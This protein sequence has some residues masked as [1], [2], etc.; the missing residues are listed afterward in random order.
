MK[1]QYINLNLVHSSLPFILCLSISYPCTS[2]T[3]GM[4]ALEG[5]LHGWSVDPQ[6]FKDPL[7]ERGHLRR[8]EALLSLLSARPLYLRLPVSDSGRA[9]IWWWRG[10]GLL[11]A[12]HQV[13]AWGQQQ[14][15]R[16][17][18]PHKRC[19]LQT[20]T[21]WSPQNFH[22]ICLVPS[23]ICCQLYTSNHLPDLWYFNQQN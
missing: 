18:N 19:Y 5:P 23:I 1:L 22:P 7:Q 17:F 4:A 9:S 21:W 15:A 11:L 14:M 12:W 13:L 3:M 16:I 20:E 6:G 10:T 8:S 2:H